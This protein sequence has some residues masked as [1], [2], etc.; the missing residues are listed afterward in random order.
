[1]RYDSKV[2]KELYRPAYAIVA[3]HEIGQ[4]HKGK[5]C[6]RALDSQEKAGEIGREER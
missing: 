3:L 1:V 2:F 5:M 4:F 6:R